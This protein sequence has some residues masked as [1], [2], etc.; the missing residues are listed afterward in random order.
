MAVLRL[1]P[2]LRPLSRP[3]VHGSPL[4]GYGYNPSWP[5]IL[6]VAH[7][8]SNGGRL[9][10]VTD[11]PVILVGG[12]V[13]LPF[14]V[15]GLSVE[16]GVAVSPVKFRLWM[17]GPV[18]AGS[19]W[20]WGADAPPSGEQVDPITGNPLN[21]SSGDCADVPGA[22]APLPPASVVAAI[23]EGNTAQLTFDRPVALS[24][25]GPEDGTITF[26]GVVPNSVSMGGANVLS[27]TTPNPIGPGSTWAIASQPGYV[28]TPLA[29]PAGGTF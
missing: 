2:K 1:K 13:S 18:P 26:D 27:F 7:D 3:R 14:A 10:V 25:S 19:A 9:F 15:A 12:A 28:M 6:S 11:R 20:T 16:E 21:A 22:Y 5:S 24:G 4:Y 29:N 8:T 23:A 17:N